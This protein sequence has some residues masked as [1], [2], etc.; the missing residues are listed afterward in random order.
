L[1]EAQ[2]GAVS[3]RVRS[4]LSITER[5]QGM[6]RR[7]L[8][9]LRPSAFG[10]ASLGELLDDL[11]KDFRRHH[12]GIAFELRH[13]DLRRSYGEAIDL[14]IY[15]CVQEGLTNSVRHASAKTVEI[16]IDDEAAPD[17]R[18]RIE[19]RDDG[20]GVDAG[21]LTGFGLRSMKERV[22]S[23]GGDCLIGSAVPQGTRLLI[24]LPYALDPLQENVA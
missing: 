4:I 16:A 17:H 21:D 18:L 5:L 13:G 10:H 12:S 1:N 9:K 23:L 7:L 14:S 15:R 8:K 24:T 3:E 2:A 22:L 11:V 20:Q 19:I 6:N